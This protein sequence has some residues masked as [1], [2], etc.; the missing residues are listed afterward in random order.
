MKQ[1][2]TK[3]EAGEIAIA[4]MSLDFVIRTVGRY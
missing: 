2:V 1:K 3:E 4:V